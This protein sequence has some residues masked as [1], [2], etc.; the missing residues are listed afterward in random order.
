MLKVTRERIDTMQ[1]EGE[2]ERKVGVVE[3]EI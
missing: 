3:S 1:N 2:R